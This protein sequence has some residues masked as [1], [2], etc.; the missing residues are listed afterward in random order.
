MLRRTPTSQPTGLD[1]PRF[2]ALY[3]RRATELLRFFM[4]RTLD[5]QVAADLTAETFA[6]AFASRGSFDP[7]RGDPGAWLHGIARHQLARYI[8]KRMV[9]TAARERAGFAEHPLSAADLERVEALIDFAEVGRRI[10]TA[11][12]QLNPHQREAVVLRVVEELDYAEIAGRLR[13]SEGA[14]RIRVSRGLRQMGLYLAATSTP[15]PEVTR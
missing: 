15:D 14:A 7:T 9:E 6:A 10:S 5:A 1:R 2:V 13:C 11:L 12:G 4:R 8:D 3:E